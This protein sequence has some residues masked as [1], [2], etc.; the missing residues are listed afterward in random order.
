M[1]MLS[2]TPSPLM[3]S[4]SQ[5]NNSGGVHWYKYFGTYLFVM[6]IAFAS[7][8]L[9]SSRSYSAWRSSSWIV[10]NF[11][12]IGSMIFP[13][14]MIIGIL[15]TIGPLIFH[16]R[17]RHHSSHPY[18]TNRIWNLFI[19]EILG[20]GFSGFLFQSISSFISYQTYYP[21]SYLSIFQSDARALFI[22]WLILFALYIT[23]GFVYR[24]FFTRKTK[25]N[26][27]LYNQALPQQSKIIG[28]S[29][30]MSK[31]SLQSSQVQAEAGQESIISQSN[32]NYTYAEFIAMLTQ[33]LELQR[34]GRLFFYALGL[35]VI[36][37]GVLVWV[38]NR[39]YYSSLYGLWFITASAFLFFGL[40][41]FLI[42]Q[43]KLEPFPRV[44]FLKQVYSIKGLLL[45][46]GA[47]FVV[48]L[49]YLFQLNMYNNYFYGLTSIEYSIMI[50]L[51][52]WMLLFLGLKS[53]QYR[54]SFRFSFS[55]IKGLMLERLG[56]KRL[57]QH[58]LAVELTKRFLLLQLESL[59]AE[60]KHA[61][62]LTIDNTIQDTIQADLFRL[63]HLFKVNDIRYYSSTALLKF[64][65]D[66]LHPIYSNIKIA[67]IN[68][69][70]DQL[71]ET[72]TQF[73]DVQIDTDMIWQQMNK[74]LTQ[75]Q[76]EFQS[77]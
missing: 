21:P 34:F 49:F 19:L 60:L 77:P 11:D 2:N 70:T 20:F 68:S 10:I 65:M 47:F 9:I 63:E 51:I 57:H 52:W 73:E 40:G 12:T 50:G 46:F 30:N 54:S 74:Q 69:Y 62:P 43:Y 18:N 66:L 6:G 22:M 23:A 56:L 38:N 61:S 44:S 7:I 42:H 13:V 55:Q 71:L 4:H 45:L 27:T 17:V 8:L 25:P 67:L 24:K 1:F 15:Y 5:P 53:Y 37:M 28:G 33:K 32:E 35:Y 26:V 58:P 41:L 76:S 14:L 48:T 75:W 31:P 3:V 29:S 72:K 64:C 16:L 59:R 36:F 39:N